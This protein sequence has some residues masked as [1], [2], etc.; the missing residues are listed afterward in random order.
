[1]HRHNYVINSW[2]VIPKELVQHA[3]RSEED[4]KMMSRLAGY[5][6]CERELRNFIVLL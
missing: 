4:D 1:M 2:R 3:W 6:G 5:L